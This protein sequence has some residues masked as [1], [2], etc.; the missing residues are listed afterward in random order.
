MS[1]YLRQQT[2][3]DIV[4]NTLGIYRQHFGTILLVYFLPVLPAAVFLTY[5]TKCQQAASF[6]P[7]G[8]AVYQAVTVLVLAPMTVTI[9]DICLGNKPSIARSYGRLR[10]VLW[11]FIGT[12]LL[13]IVSLLIGLLLAIVPG[14]VLLVLFMFALT[15]VAVERRGI[16][17]AIRRSVRL[18]KGYYWRNFFVYLVFI[19]VYLAAV[20]VFGVGLGGIAAV[21]GSGYITTCI[22]VL[23]GPLLLIPI[24]LLYYDMRVRKEHFDA[25]ALALDMM[26]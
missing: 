23:L 22:R 3:G 18:G 14:L 20:I 4:R 8:L 10:R 11:R 2:A 17:E 9:S 7:I 6:V 25:E 12:Y 21:P 13:V 26:G 19:G 5:C 1:C 24:V 16:F 15:V